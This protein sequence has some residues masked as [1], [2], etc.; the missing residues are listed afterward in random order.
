MKN[1]FNLFY[2]NS[3]ASLPRGFYLKLPASHQYKDGDYVVYECT[4]SVENF[5]LSRHWLNKDELL[6]KKIGAMPGEKYS[7]NQ[8]NLQFYANGV[9]RGQV[10]LTDR[11]NLPMPV[12]RGEHEVPENEFLPV[13]DHPRSFDGRYT[14]TV[15]LNNIQAKV[16]PVFTEFHW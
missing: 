6:L 2:F 13:A 7:I 12:I 16:I 9:Y 8:D 14:G 1:S 15:P 4:P 3:T 10:Y 5:A 11:A